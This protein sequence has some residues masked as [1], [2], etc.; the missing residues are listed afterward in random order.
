ML[1]KPAAYGAIGATGGSFLGQLG[2]VM[3]VPRRLVV[4][5]LMS[6]LDALGV[7][8]GAPPPA[9]DAGQASPRQVATGL[10]GMLGMANAGQPGGL[11]T[12]GVS[13]AMLASGPARMMPTSLP[14][15]PED[16]MW[17]PAPEMDE[18]AAEPEAPQSA[19]AAILSGGGPDV[20]DLTRRLGGA[21]ERTTGSSLGLGNAVTDLPISMALDPLTWAGGLA[22]RRLGGARP[23]DPAA[24]RL[25][26]FAAQARQGAA[27]SLTPGP[28]YA[29]P[30]PGAP[31]AAASSSPGAAALQTEQFMGQAGAQSPLAAALAEAAPPPLPRV[32][33]TPAM[34]GARLNPEFM[35]Q[36]QLSSMAGY[37]PE[38]VEA[39]PGLEQV[40]LSGGRLG[41]P[42]AGLARR[43]K[44]IDPSLEDAL[45]SYGWMSDAQQSGRQLSG[46]L[47][48]G[49]GQLPPFA[50]VR[51]GGV[52]PTGLPLPPGATSYD[53]FLAAPMGDMMP[54]SP[55]VMGPPSTGELARAMADTWRRQFESNR[56]DRMAL[57]ERL[58]A[59]EAPTIGPQLPLGY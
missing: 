15:G 47:N 1:S 44:A 7:G 38:M 30:G 45:S 27:P 18:E 22:G 29:P 23:A 12:P 14:L 55:P 5:A 3:G 32:P 16:Q 36:A 24:A 41:E 9:P 58:K 37:R 51:G 13:A 31:A 19:L 43:Y 11:I 49:P 33:P 26:R 54:V 52:R 25:D 35:E 28:A 6:G 42:V 34:P 2:E 8:D 46:T 4:S 50:A 59:L 21:L 56:M 39:L 17:P 20:A 48:Y 40:G 10:A 53:D 57:L